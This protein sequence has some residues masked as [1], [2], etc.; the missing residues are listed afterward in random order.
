VDDDRTLVLVSGAQLSTGIGG[1]A[2]A[3]RRR[4]PYDIPLM[5][6]RRDTVG[7]QSLLMGTALSAPGA[8]LAVQAVA[9][10]VLARR[11]SVRA[12]QA[13]GVLGAMMVPGYLVE[14]LT[15]QG[16]RHGAW[17]SAELRLALAGAA[18]AAGMVPLAARAV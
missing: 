5:H 6:G 1:L 15:R 3:L 11:H 17:D 8:M 18:L 16:L 2:L 4:H 12:A 13:L 9:T 10:A 14:G 7:R